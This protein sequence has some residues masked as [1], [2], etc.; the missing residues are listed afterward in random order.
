MRWTGSGH[1]GPWRFFKEL[2]LDP[3]AAVLTQQPS[4]PAGGL[5]KMPTA[6]PHPRGPDGGSRMEP[7]S[8]RF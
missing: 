5:V 8:A 3:E 2:G 6:R 7:K 1:V 4:D